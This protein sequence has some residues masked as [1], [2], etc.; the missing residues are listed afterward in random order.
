MA[1]EIVTLRIAGLGDIRPQTIAVTMAL[2]EAARS[3]EAKIKH[4]RLSQAQLLQALRGAP[5]IEIFSRKSDNARYEPDGPLG[6]LILTGHV[7]KRSPSLRA[8]EGDLAISGRSKTGDLVDSSAEDEAGEFKNKKATEVFGTLAKDYQ[9]V[10]DSD[11]AHTPKTVFRIR[12]GETV[13]QAADRWARSEGFTVTDTPKG[14]LKFYKADKPKRHEG[15]IREGLTYWPKVLDASAVHDDSKRF[16]KV[17]VRA[18]AP[19]GYGPDELRIEDEASDETVKRKRVRVIVPPELVAK[20]DARTR[21]KWHRDRA[22]G[23]GTTSEVKL[24]GWRDEKGLFWTP[25]W[26]S[27][28]ELP[29]LDLIQDMLVKS[30][31]LEQAD[32]DG[33]GTTCK[34]SLVDPRAFGGK[35]GKGAKS[36]DLIGKAGGDDT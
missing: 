20:K 12:P 18:Q 17:K 22:A 33:G 14:D 8:E 19:D 7:E 15:S 29:S 5:K 16:G 27:H 25:G 13:F 31:T 1:F 4:P 30:V 32:A 26:Q 10:I 23:E 3:F 11:V 9:I 34:L 36:G 6:D 35:K 28:T 24:L 2:D 21:A